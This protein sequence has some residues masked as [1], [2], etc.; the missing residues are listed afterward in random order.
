MKH[1]KIARQFGALKVTDD[2]GHVSIYC[3]SVAHEGTIWGVRTYS[4]FAGGSF[5]AAHYYINPDGS[6]HRAQNVQTIDLAED[7]R[8]PGW[9]HRNVEHLEC[10]LCGRFGAVEVRSERLAPIL[11]GCFA[12][13]VS[14]LSLR[15]LAARVTTNRKPQS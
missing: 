7:E 15:A 1:R 11:A 8:T 2:Q 14:E 9:G 10:H 4:V 3:D 5:I 12:A 6:T 13:G